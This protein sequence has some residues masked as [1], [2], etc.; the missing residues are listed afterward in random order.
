M[1]GCGLRPN[2]TMHALEETVQPPYL[3]GPPVVFLMADSS[4]NTY[5]KEYRTHN[6]NGYR[7][8]YDRV[9]QLDA[10]T[11]LRRGPVLQAEAFLLDTAGLRQAVIP[12]LQKDPLFFVER[13]TDTV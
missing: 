4:G 13:K 6:F 1:L 11:F 12:A 8:R 7:Q 3:F 9:E 2:T 5:E 10:C